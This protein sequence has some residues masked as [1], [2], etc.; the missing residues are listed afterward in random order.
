MCWGGGRKRSHY[1]R[2]RPELIE[3]NVVTSVRLYRIKLRTNEKL[4]I[5][6]NSIKLVEYS[7]ILYNEK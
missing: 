5:M 4:L 7:V 2:F 3:G 6:N 1:S